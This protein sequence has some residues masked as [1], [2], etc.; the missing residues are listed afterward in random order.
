M[1]GK[2]SPQFAEDNPNS[3]LIAS[4]NK[5]YLDRVNKYKRKPKFKIGDKGIILQLGIKTN[6]LKPV[7]HACFYLNFASTKS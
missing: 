1:L 7:Y 4:H 5:K 3:S 6:N 2:K